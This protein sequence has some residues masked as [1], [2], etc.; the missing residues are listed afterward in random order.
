M[1]LAYSEEGWKIHRGLT[2]RN[3]RSEGWM[4]IWELREQTQM[5]ME[6]ERNKA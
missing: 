1:E 2:V 3:M 4:P 5:D 6:K